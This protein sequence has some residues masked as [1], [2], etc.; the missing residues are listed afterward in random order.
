MISFRRSTNGVTQ[1]WDCKVIHKERQRCESTSWRGKAVKSSCNSL[2][3]QRMDHGWVQR[4]SQ[5]LEL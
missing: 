2:H 1:T 3:N 4:A 5:V